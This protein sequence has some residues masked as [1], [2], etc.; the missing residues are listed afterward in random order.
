MTRDRRGLA[1]AAQ[2]PG[3]RH[4]RWFAFWVLL[5]AAGCGGGGPAKVPVRGQVLRDNKPLQYGNVMFQPVA[6]GPMARGRIQ[7]DGTFVLTTT[8]E[9]DGVLPGRCRVRITAFEGQ[10][11]GASDPMK[12]EMPLGQSAIA[13][14]YQ[15]F[16]ASQIVIDVSPEM[17]QP[18]IIRLD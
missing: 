4:R 16:G 12:E 9:G 14:R 8:N 11:A 18:V 1:A 7:P 10:R 15:S 17:E 2:G 13:E 5:A 6:G 3:S